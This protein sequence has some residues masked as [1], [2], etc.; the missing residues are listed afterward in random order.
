MT[1]APALVGQL[2]REPADVKLVGDDG[3]CQMDIHSIL[4][5]TLSPY[6]QIMLNDNQKTIHIRGADIDVLNIIR[7]YAYDGKITGL[8]NQNLDKVNMV[9]DMYNIVGII[10]ECQ[11]F[12]KSTNI[13]ER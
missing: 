8:S 1:I 13:Q 6:F 12:M 7:E 5:M 11:I 3:K 2:I 9:A 4:L 10:N